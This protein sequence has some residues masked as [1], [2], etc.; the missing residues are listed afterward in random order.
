[1]TNIPIEGFT[2]NHPWGGEFQGEISI[3]KGG[4]VSVAFCSSKV[5]SIA[6]PAE[7][8]PITI[9]ARSKGARILL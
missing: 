1:M 5:K 7:A 8:Y 9:T 6:I 3:S 2:L 4:G